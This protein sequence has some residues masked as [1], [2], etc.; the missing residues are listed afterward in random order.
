MAC[1]EHSPYTNTYSQ[2][3]HYHEEFQFFPKNFLKNTQE[4]Q[5]SVN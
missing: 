5:T 2:K 1:K 3:P 4:K